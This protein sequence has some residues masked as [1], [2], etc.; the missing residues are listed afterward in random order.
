MNSRKMYSNGYFL[1][2]EQG[3]DLE[4]CALSRGVKEEIEYDF[5]IVSK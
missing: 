3:L 4:P 1:Q 5:E 2:L